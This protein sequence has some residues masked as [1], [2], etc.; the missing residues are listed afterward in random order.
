MEVQAMQN[1]KKR[2]TRESRE[3]S[4]Q[5]TRCKNTYKNLATMMAK[6]V[7]V[8]LTKDGDY[9]AT[10][11][12]VVPARKG[13]G[14]EIVLSPN[15]NGNKYSKVKFRLTGDNSWNPAYQD[16]MEIIGNMKDWDDVIGMELGI[17][18]EQS[19]EGFWNIVEFFEFEEETESA[20]SDEEISED[21]MFDSD[22]EE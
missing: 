21:D 20:D 6:E 17:T 15:R 3:I 14:Y 13:E 7:G 19:V 18:L 1:F 5:S 4:N 22:E 11:D 8:P 16:F 12:D 10:I 2:F 9:T